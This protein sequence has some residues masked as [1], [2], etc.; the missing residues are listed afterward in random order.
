MIRGLVH[1][2][3]EERLGELGLFS[4]EKRR[5]WGDLIA[6]F[7][8]LKEAYKKDGDRLFSRACG[9]RARGNCFRLKVGRSR[10]DM[11][12]KFITE[13]GEAPA[14][15]AQGGGRCPTPGNIQGQAGWGPEQP[16]LVEDGPPLC[17]RLGLDDL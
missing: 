9:N 14:Q 6:D 17:S 2:C 12:K 10:L 1:L 15:V 8:Y 7:Q 16:D 3:C 11:R 13:G 5:M 4:L